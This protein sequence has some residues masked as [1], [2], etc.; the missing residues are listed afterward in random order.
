MTGI[1]HAL[2]QSVF[3]H[4]KSIDWYHY[5]I[6]MGM[7]IPLVK[8]ARM[9]VAFLHRSD[10]MGIRVAILII[11]LSTLLLLLLQC[12]VFTPTQPNR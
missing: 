9:P 2:H 5:I 12:G 3:K 4:G 6:R 1:L 7:I 10:E 11:I 8:I